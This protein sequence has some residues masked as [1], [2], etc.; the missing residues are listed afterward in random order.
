MDEQEYKHPSFGNIQLTRRSGGNKTVFGSGAKYRTTVVLK[1]ST[2]YY[3]RKLS[4]DWIAPAKNLV[5]VEMSEAQFAQFI[6]SSG[7]GE[8][9]PCTIKYITGQEIEDCPEIEMCQQL[10][11]EL[12]SALK[13]LQDVMSELKA[14]VKELSDKPRLTK[15]D[16]E[17][18]N[19]VID[20]A[21]RAVDGDL[22][23][24]QEQFD[25]AMDK[26]VNAAEIEA[27]A[28][29]ANIRNQAGMLAIQKLLEGERD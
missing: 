21:K 16:K 23:F 3:T 11:T 24:I 26:S 6:M 5:E 19:R 12:D 15:E 17:R 4:Y 9:T 25:E 13:G 10:H 1:I 18:L 8:G 29:V 2:A 28:Y 7:V 14:V 22:Q 27:E 20:T